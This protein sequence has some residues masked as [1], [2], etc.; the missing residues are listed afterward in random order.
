M[1][2]SIPSARTYLFDLL[3]GLTGTGESLEGVKVV[4][5]GYWDTIVES[6]VLV[7][8]DA[9]E[10]DWE[11]AR[12]GA[13]RATETYTLPVRL[14]TYNIA[15]DLPAVEARL[16]ELVIAVQAAIRSDLTFG[17][18]VTKSI[19]RR[20]PAVESGP[21]DNNGDVVVSRC[22]LEIVCDATVSF[23]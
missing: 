4:R 9:R 13:L 22:T 12:L 7:V 11:W 8:E 20:I 23:A 5:T 2:S 18:V 6:D 10:I 16:W 1:A 14:E 15:G 21:T 17:N 3:D 19:P